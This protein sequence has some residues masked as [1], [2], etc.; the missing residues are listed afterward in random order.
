M[1]YSDGVPNKVDHIKCGRFCWAIISKIL[2]QRE[3]DI[4]AHVTTPLNLNSITMVLLFKVKFI[5][6]CRLTTAQKYVEYIET[7][8]ARN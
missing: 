8:P 1:R 7:E 4:G 3:G 6:N 2:K 5:L